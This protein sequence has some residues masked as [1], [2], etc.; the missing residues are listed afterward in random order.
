M[1]QSFRF[2]KYINTAS[3]VAAKEKREHRESCTGSSMLLP[4]NESHC[5][6]SHFIGQRSHMALS[7][8]KGEGKENLPSV[9]GKRKGNICE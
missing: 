9:P 6:H 4:G 5:F 7:N 2:F 8:F 3:A 1:A